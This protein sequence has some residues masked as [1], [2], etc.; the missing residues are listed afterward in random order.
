MKYKHNNLITL[1]LNTKEVRLKIMNLS[2]EI[3]YGYYLEFIKLLCN[4]GLLLLSHD[5]A[6]AYFQR[7]Q[8]DNKLCV[9]QTSSFLY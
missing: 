9:F 1:K 7:I 2:A 3:G 6:I 5:Q 4:L 8:T